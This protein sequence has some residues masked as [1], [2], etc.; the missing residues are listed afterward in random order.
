MG[1]GIIRQQCNSSSVYVTSHKGPET[2][3]QLGQYQICDWRSPRRELWLG[4]SE[5]RDPPSPR[6]ICMHLPKLC[7]STDSRSIFSCK[8]ITSSLLKLKWGLF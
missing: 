5:D 4:D 8:E 3:T 1:V 2:L 6:G 7:I